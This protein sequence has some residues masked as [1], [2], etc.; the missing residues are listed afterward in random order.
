MST[1]ARKN[2]QR[3][4]SAL[5]VALIFTGLLTLVTIGVSSLISRET[6]QVRSV[7]EASAAF[8]AAESGVELALLDI[9]ESDPGTNVDKGTYELDDD[10]NLTV[11][12]EVKAKTNQVP[13]LAGYE[14]ELLNSGFNREL[15]ASET[16]NPNF[17]FEELKLNES[18]R[19][20][21]KDDLKRF[22]V[23]YY[24]PL[25]DFLNTSDLNQFDILRW[26]LF[27]K[28]EVGD[29]DSL[30]DFLPGRNEDDLLSGM[31]P[32]R[33]ASMGTDGYWDGGVFFPAD[34]ESLEGKP[35]C[36]DDEKNVCIFIA[37]FMQSHTD[38]YLVLTNLLDTSKIEGVHNLEERDAASIYYRVVDNENANILNTLGNIVSP[39]TRIEATG[40]FGDAKKSLSVDIAPDNFLPIFDFA[41]Y[42]PKL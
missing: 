25:A 27:G 15:I 39:T 3:R 42:R 20:G 31:S 35:P 14:K 26:K 29:I 11:E 17:G 7:L 33:P 4:G 13:L 16:N 12:Y 22:R 32:G 18:V 41:L 23:D 37:D 34:Q 9:Q 40:N 24:Y 10:E 30:N 6:R 38:R 21:F 2:R 8:Y 36:I 5:L 19:I 1:L 28:N